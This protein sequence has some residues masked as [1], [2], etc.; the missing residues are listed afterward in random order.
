MY[1]FMYVLLQNQ[2]YALLLGSIGIFIIM[3]VVMYLSRNLD[4]YKIELNN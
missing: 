4:W 1:G 2:D 3:A